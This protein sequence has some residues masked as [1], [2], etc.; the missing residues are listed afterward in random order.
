MAK[1][2]EFRGYDLVAPHGLSGT[3]SNV[4]DHHGIVNH[5]EEHSIIGNEQLANFETEGA[6]FASDGEPMR[7]GLER[8]D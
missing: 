5:C 8:S 6:I 1:L 2:I 3:L 4:Q 7:C